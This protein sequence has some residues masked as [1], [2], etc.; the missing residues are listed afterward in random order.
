MGRSAR[1]ELAPLLMGLALWLVQ[2]GPGK[3]VREEVS[4]SSPWPGLFEESWAA[5]ERLMAQNSPRQTGLLATSR[6]CPL[7]SPCR[8]RLA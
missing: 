8:Q 7:G 5:A 2:R 4:Q 3:L 1:W 6:T